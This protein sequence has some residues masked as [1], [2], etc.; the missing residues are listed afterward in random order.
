LIKDKFGVEYSDM[1]VWRILTSWNMHHAKPYV[2]DK[3]RPDD[4][5]GFL[6]TC[7]CLV[8]FQE[9]LHFFE[10]KIPNSLNFLILAFFR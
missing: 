9:L 6:F 3:R 10:F 2:L 5:G 1:Q 7:I 8:I 4:A